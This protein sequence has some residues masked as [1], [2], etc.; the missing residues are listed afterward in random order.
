MNRS[1]CV[2][3]EGVRRYF[4]GREWKQ[5]GKGAHYDTGA[6]TWRETA[7]EHPSGDLTSIH[8]HTSSMCAAGS[9]ITPARVNAQ[10]IDQRIPTKQKIGS[11]KNANNFSRIF[12][13]SFIIVAT[14]S[15]CNKLSF[16]SIKNGF[17]KNLEKLLAFFRDPL[18]CLVGKHPQNLV[19][20]LCIYS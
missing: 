7:P 3:P 2:D 19:N 16:P 12:R 8:H 15:Y 5:E 9:S 18:F 13:N 11:R 4:F 1:R 14:E 17:G 20:N 10:I 6:S